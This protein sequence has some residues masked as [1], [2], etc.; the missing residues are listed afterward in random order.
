M[1]K[2]NVEAKVLENPKPS[3]VYTR[4]GNSAMV[5][6]AWIAD[7][8]GKVKL[9]LWNDQGNSFTKGDTIQIKNASVSTFRGERQLCLG[10]TG[11]ISVLQK[12]TPITKQELDLVTKN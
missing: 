3:P 6:N 2:I 11:T 9:C 7:E 1:K 5:T 12:Q 10:R 4:F 8:S